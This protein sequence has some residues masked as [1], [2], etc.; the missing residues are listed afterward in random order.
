MLSAPDQPGRLPV[1]D[2]LQGMFVFLIPGT[3]D[4]FMPVH[5]FIPGPE[6]GEPVDMRR[7]LLGAVITADGTVGMLKAAVLVF[8]RSV[9]DPLHLVFFRFCA[10]AAVRTFHPVAGLVK[11]PAELM[12]LVF[13]LIFAGSA[14]IPVVLF[15]K[16]PGQAVLFMLCLIAADCAFH[17]VTGFIKSSCQLMF[18]FLGMEAAV[19]AFFPVEVCIISVF[20]SVFLRLR[21]VAAAAADIPVGTVIMLSGQFMLLGKRMISAVPALKPVA[22]LIELFH[23]IVF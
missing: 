8:R 23:E 7:C 13:R 9:H 20:H 14:H 19:R 15:V 6:I 18:F 22:G 21:T 12:G 3:A 11:G 10:E 5:F 4:T 16:L 17:P 2:P 1:N